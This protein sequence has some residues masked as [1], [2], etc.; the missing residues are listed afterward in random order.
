M[1][2]EEDLTENFHSLLDYMLDCLPDKKRFDTDIL[3]NG[4]AARALPFF[5]K[6]R[7]NISHGKSR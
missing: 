1:A 3:A 4:I 5:Q 2:T 6:K 7:G